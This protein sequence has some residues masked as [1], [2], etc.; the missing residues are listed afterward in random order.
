[1]LVPPDWHERYDQ[2]VEERR[3]PEVGPKRDA[4][5]APVGA[6]GFRL[7]DALART[8]APLDAMMLPAVETLRRVWARHFER[9]KGE[10]DGGGPDRGARLRPV[11]GRGPGD[12]PESP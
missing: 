10:Q 4:Y 6:D 7:L 3:I 11:Q 8:D 12:R 1:M 9:I 2:R 5:V